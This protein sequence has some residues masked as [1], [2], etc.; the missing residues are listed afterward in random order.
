[1]QAIPYYFYCFLLIESKCFL[2]E[3]WHPEI[4][5]SK[6]LQWQTLP[7]AIL[8]INRSKSDICLI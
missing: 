2:W 3:L 6:S 4:L 7:A 1:M 8:E 5:S